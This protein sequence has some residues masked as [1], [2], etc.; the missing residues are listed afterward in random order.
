MKAKSAAGKNLSVENHF[1]RLDIDTRGVA[2]TLTEKATGVVWQMARSSSQD[3]TLEDANQSRTQHAFASSQDKEV[4]PARNGLPGAYIFLRDLGIGIHAF[5]DA[6]SLV[7]EVER[8]VGRGPAKVRDVLFPRH[9]L[10]PR[11]PDT[12]ST[13]TM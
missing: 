11:K 9:F 10:L 6:R 2:W 13:W 8:F 4:R 1:L 3:V 7:V 12:F 5:L